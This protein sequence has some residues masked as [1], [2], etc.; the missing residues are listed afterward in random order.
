[1]NILIDTHIFLWASG[2]DGYLSDKGSQIIDD[3]NNSVYISAVSVWEICI[4]WSIDR[5]DLPQEPVELIKNV[6][7]ESELIQVP[8]TF[9]DSYVVTQL[10]LDDHKDPFDRLLAAQA[11]NRGFSIM[12]ADKKFKKYDL[13]ILFYSKK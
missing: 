7:K 13:D 4:K 8:V 11:I 5:L 2:I 10:P 3:P 1:M 6:L 12:T 9:S